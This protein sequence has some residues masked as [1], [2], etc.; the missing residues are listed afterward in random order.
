MPRIDAV[1]LQGSLVEVG[2]LEGNHVGGQ[3]LVDEQIAAIV[4]RRYR[5]GDLQQRIG[6]R[7]GA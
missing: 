6:G 3:N 4:L 1:D 7:V 2:A 5:H